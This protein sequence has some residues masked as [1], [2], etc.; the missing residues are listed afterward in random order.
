MK[1]IYLWGGWSRNYGDLAMYLAQTRLLQEQCEE[2]IEFIPINSD[3]D[4][5]SGYEP[6]FSRTMLEEVNSFGDML[7]IGAGGQLMPRAFDGVKNHS[8]Y[9]F[10]IP[11]HF[12]DAITIPI[13]VYGVGLNMYWHSESLSMTAIDHFRRLCSVARLVSVRDRLTRN[14][15]HHWGIRNV[16]VIPDPAFFTEAG[17]A[18]LPDKDV[19]VPL[20]GFN[21]A[22]DRVEGRLGRCPEREV[23]LN[24][25]INCK[26]V[27]EGLG[28]G[29][30]LYIPHVSR[31]DMS[32]IN[33]MRQVLGNKITSLEECSPSIYPEQPW[34]VTTLLGYY[35]LIDVMVA[36]RWHSH[37]FAYSRTKPVVSLGDTFKNDAFVH[38]YP[39]VMQ[40]DYETTGN[41][42]EE[43]IRRAYRG[44]EENR[45]STEYRLLYMRHELRD[46]N[47]KVI[48]LL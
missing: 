37:V 46:F 18:W 9:Q 24:S 45:Q 15:C 19:A 8:G 41:Q 31:Y 44:R 25:A 39:N 27:L 35:D 2:K 40:C 6:M 11:L 14:M 30:V 34:G 28:G 38:D 3:K 1:R 16:H 26:R 17:N 23:L 4:E 33:V 20:I 43:C 10:N 21:W 29:S 5:D 22:G 42:L 48:D 32:G 12:I 36:T 7:I 13:V 47:Q